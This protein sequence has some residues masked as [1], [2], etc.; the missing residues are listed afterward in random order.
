MLLAKLIAKQEA[1]DLTDSAF[2]ALLGIPRSTWQLTRTRRKAL[3]LRVA[4][5]TLRAFPDLTSEAAAFL[6]HGAD[7]VVKKEEAEQGREP[8]RVA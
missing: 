3:G 2:A 4:R 8:A 6:L 7:E 1:L 5:R